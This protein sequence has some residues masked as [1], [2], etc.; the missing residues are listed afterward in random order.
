MKKY[1]WLVIFIILS[2]LTYGYRVPT[3]LWFSNIFNFLGPFALAAYLTNVAWGMYVFLK[4]I[5]FFFEYEDWTK[6]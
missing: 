4:S 5:G 1:L 2:I 3:E 6:K